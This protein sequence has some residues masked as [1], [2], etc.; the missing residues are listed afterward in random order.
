MFGGRGLLQF[1]KP[2]VDG[3]NFLFPLYGGGSIF[4]GEGIAVE[5][6]P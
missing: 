1:W 6:E 4:G 5:D 2:R 3:V